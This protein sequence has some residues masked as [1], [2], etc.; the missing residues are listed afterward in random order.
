MP[1]NDIHVHYHDGNRHDQLIV[2]AVRPFHDAVW[3]HV[4]AA[5]FVRH[6]LQGPHIRISVRADAETFARHVLPAAHDILGDY[7]ARQP[8]PATSAPDSALA[9]HQ[10]LAE[11]ERVEEPLLPWRPDNSLHVAAHDDRRAILGSQAAVDL[12]AEF[13]T[14]TT[15]FAFDMTAHIH[16]GGQRLRLAFDL[17]LAVAHALSGYGLGRGF[18]SYRSHAEAFLCGWPEGDGQRDQF[19]RWY[20]SHS[21]ELVDR[22]GTVVSAVDTASA[23]VPFVS[24]WIAALHQFDVKGRQL[25]EQGALDMNSAGM[26]AAS[27]F[28]PLTEVSELHRVLAT[29]GARPLGPPTQFATYR[30]LLNYTY[31][32]LTRLGITPF[33][34]L[35]LCH[36]AAN[37]VE[38][39]YGCSAL[40]LASGV[41]PLVEGSD[42]P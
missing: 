39:R 6:W 5:Y 21:S 34:R 30:L 33:E 13:L 41:E 2:E 37:A 26:P 38:E 36:L 15:E 4:D 1:W 7:L 18:L 9:Q 25:I 24:E 31:L 12:L 27:G 14:C 20:R 32:Q 11:L 42:A 17:M 35:L 28:R 22:V 19:D 3:A 29:R 8:S 40:Q 16:A 10:R 23:G